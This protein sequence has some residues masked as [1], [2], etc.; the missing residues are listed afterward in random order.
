MFLIGALSFILSIVQLLVS[1]YWQGYTFIH[2]FI[3][4]RRLFLLFYIVQLIHSSSSSGLLISGVR[5]RRVF[6]Y[7]WV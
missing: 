1:G 6:L 3:N 5:V 4:A 7:E 2:S